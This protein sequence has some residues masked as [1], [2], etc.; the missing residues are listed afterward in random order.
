MPRL[1][2]TF[3]QMNPVA[4]FTGARIETGAANFDFDEVRVGR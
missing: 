1:T 4:P 2:L 3:V